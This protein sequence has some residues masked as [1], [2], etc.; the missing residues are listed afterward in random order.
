MG[1]GYK[2]FTST[3]LTAADLNNY[4]QNQSV[5]Y[6]SSTGA[7]D[8]AVTGPL[9]GMTAY[10]GSNDLNEGLYT[11]NGTSWRKGPGWNAP[12]GYTA[13]ATQSGSNVVTSGTTEIT[14]VSTASFNSVANRVYQISVLTNTYGTVSGDQF[15]I[16]VRNGSLT[17]T[18]LL[19][20]TISAWNAV[21]TV[22]SFTI[23][24]TSLTTASSNGLYLTMQRSSGTGTLTS[25]YLSA[26]ASIM[27]TDIGSN[28][29]PV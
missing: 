9:D 29:A 26:P 25:N 15:I 3:V 8:A 1:S 21:Y 23:A 14:I 20:Q 6:F 13:S 22:A 10:I 12:W 7:R 2:N 16:R 19:S 5:M 27:M 11:Y 18:V 24:T 17:G 28:G 4:C